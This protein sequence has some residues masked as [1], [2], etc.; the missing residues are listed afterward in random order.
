MATFEGLFS[1]ACKASQLALEQPNAFLAIDGFEIGSRT[2]P[3]YLVDLRILVLFSAEKDGNSAADREEKKGKVWLADPS[4]G[5]I[6]W[7]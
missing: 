5:S 7:A 2:V 6:M 1:A 4:I 3:G